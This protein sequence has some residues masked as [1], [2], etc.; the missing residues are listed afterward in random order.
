MQYFL[1]LCEPRAS[2][3]YLKSKHLSSLDR[4]QLTLNASTQPSSTFAMAASNAKL[5]F[6]TSEEVKV[7]PTF[8]S[9]GLKEDLL[10]G[11][12]AYSAWWTSKAVLSIAEYTDN[13]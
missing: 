13:P 1:L 11:V 10:R 3:D 5:S 4:Y 8:D 9:M 2:F 7:A 12:Y 6:E